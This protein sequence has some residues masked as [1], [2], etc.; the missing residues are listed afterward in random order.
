MVTTFI[1]I[2]QHSTL[3]NEQVLTFSSSTNN[4]RLTAVITMT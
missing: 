1:T 4:T 2:N 3:S